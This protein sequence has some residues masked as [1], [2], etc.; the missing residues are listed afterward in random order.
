M[1]KVIISLATV[2]I[3]FA[4]CS[5]S[6]LTR[7][8]AGGSLTQEQFD[9]LSSE[10]LQGT[11]KGLYSMIYTMSS[12]DHDEFGQRSIDLWGDILSCD[13][14]VTNKTYGWLYQDEQMLTVSGRT[15]TIWVFYYDIIHNAN[16]TIKS[17][18]NSSGDLMAKIAKYGYPSKATEYKY[19]SEETNYALYLAQALAIRAYCYGN[20]VRWYTPTMESSYFAGHT[21][22]DYPCCPV[23]NETNMD[24]PQ[25]LS[26]SGEVYA[27][28]F[29]DL[30]NAIN[31]FDEFGAYYEELNGAMFTRETKLEINL[32]VARGLLAYAYLNAAPY[33]DKIDAAKCKNYYRAAFK[34]A[35]AVI[36]SGEFR[37]IPNTMLYTTGFN[38]VE[39]P[40]WMWGQD[41]VTETA[42]GL[43]SWFGQCDIHSYSYAWAGDTKVLDD[44][45]KTL[46]PLWDGRSGW[47]NDGS[48]N[49]K[50]KDC[51][52]GKFFSAQN[53]NSTKEED[54]DREWLS[55]NV[56]MRIESMYLI[57]AEACYFLDSVNVCQDYLN[58]I[59][60]ERLNLSY[61]DALDEQ[62]AYINSLAGNKD[63]L[64]KQ[65][66]YNWRIE[67]W[68]EGYG[69]QTFR[70][71]T[72]K[73][74][75]GNNHDYSKGTE[76]NAHDSQFNM[77]IPSSEATY[78]PNI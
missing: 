17:I 70:R 22:D 52:D 27:Q 56:F 68:G 44:N 20:L 19:T 41:V 53:P 42:G 48:K 40:S 39:E 43:K 59:T 24:S 61:P 23:Y 62:N 66:A 1:K 5:D 64:L 78:N 15:G 58:G 29:Q 31:L 28:I 14:A 6:F 47:F 50:F 8:P 37:V 11:L 71:L 54:I 36:K 7:N 72:K 35:D 65:I 18:N 63:E 30:T 76:I 12:S 67:M 9:A 16:T 73:T 69:L 57:A 33:Y 26:A 45:L 3:V 32:N 51:P 77:N 21:I 49:S 13:I 46:I 38:S 4:S 10:K 34:H 75:R 55:D 74:K 60:S 25:P 2:A